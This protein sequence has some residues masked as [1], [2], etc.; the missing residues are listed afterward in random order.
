MTD[1]V[2]NST[3]HHTKHINRA[4]LANL[5]HRPLKLGRFVYKVYWTKIR[6]SKGIFNSTK[7][8]KA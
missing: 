4:I 6:S 7:D 1:D 5:H 2:I 3:Q 8:S